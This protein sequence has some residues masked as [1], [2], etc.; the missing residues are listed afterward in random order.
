MPSYFFVEAKLEREKNC[1]QPLL[2][3]TSTV[4]LADYRIILWAHAHTWS[5][6]ILDGLVTSILFFFGEV[7]TSNIT[8][9]RCSQR[10]VRHFRLKLMQSSMK[11]WAAD[12]ELIAG[13][14][15]PRRRT[16]RV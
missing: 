3:E 13:R 1:R 16:F 15:G 12:D 7:V 5:L 9:S 8:R 10:I 4:R 14:T 6:A 11:H 2:A